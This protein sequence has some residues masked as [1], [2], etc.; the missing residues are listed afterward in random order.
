MNN[1]SMDLIYQ[2]CIM[3]TTAGAIYGGI[4][5]DI[6]RLH[7]RVSTLSE[8]LEYERSRLDRIIERRNSNTR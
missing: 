7:E 5:G 1:I 4:R 2:I 3:L 8:D 6:K